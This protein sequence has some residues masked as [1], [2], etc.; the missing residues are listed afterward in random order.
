MT[1]SNQIGMLLRTD[2]DDGCGLLSRLMIPLCFISAR[3]SAL[4]EH[5]AA[6]PAA[7]AESEEHSPTPS[8]FDAIDF[9]QLQ[10]LCELM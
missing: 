4:K 6:A 10:Q 8:V 2:G 7:F 5:S 9:N 3:L 1:R